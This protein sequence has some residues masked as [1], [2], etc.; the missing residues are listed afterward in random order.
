MSYNSWSEHI[1]SLVWTIDYDSGTLTAFTCQFLFLKT[2]EENLQGRAVSWVFI[3]WRCL[4]FHPQEL[5]GLGLMFCCHHLET[6]HHLIFEFVSFN[7]RVGQRS[8]PHVEETGERCV[9]FIFLLPIVLECLWGPMETGFL[10][11]CLYTGQGNV[12]CLLMT[13]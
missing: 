6:L 2:M 11:T 5:P 1:F 12:L 4:G 13:E 10:G 9:L 7:W 3:L 8:M